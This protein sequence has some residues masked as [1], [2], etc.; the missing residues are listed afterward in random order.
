LAVK[1]K[2]SLPSWASWDWDQKYLPSDIHTRRNELNVALELLQ[3]YTFADHDEG[4]LVVLGVGLLLRECWRAV[5]VEEDDETSPQFLHESLLGMKR[6]KEVIKVI[7]KVISKLPS[8]DTN[9]EMCYENGQVP[10]C[11]GLMTRFGLPD[12][13]DT[14]GMFWIEYG[15]VST[16]VWSRLF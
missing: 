1:S 12:C 8:L 6:T 7:K 11:L 9:Q 16:A 10:T 3:K 15:L 13:Y 5:E 4:T 2:L 14:P